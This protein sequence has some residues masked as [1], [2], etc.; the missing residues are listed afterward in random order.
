MAWKFDNN[1][2]RFVSAILIVLIS[3]QYM[4]L[5]VQNQQIENIL[6][7]LVAFLVGGALLGNKNKQDE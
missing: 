6:Y 2:L 1:N 5:R 4:Y 3:A 7:L